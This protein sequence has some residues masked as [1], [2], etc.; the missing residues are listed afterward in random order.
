M[1][2]LAF[3]NDICHLPSLIKSKDIFIFF[4]LEEPVFFL[5]H[6]TQAHLGETYFLN[7][8]GKKLLS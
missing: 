4:L 3:Q 8:T 7:N 6:L 5:T 1:S 2:V